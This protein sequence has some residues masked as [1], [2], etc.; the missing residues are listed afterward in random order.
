MAIKSA[1]NLWLKEHFY[2]EKYAL[3]HCSYIGNNASI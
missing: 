1:G 3:T 2:L